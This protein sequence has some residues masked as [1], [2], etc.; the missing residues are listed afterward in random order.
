MK[1]AKGG[2]RRSLLGSLGVCTAVVVMAG[3]Y[4]HTYHVGA[5]APTGT[6][7]Y[8]QWRHHWLA[9]LIDPDQ[10]MALEEI[11]PSGNATIK[12]EAT[13]LNGLVTA[14]IG[15]VYSPTTVTVR[16]VTGSDADLEFDEAQIAKIVSDPSFLD[17]VEA[18]S[19]ELLEEA[20]D[21]QLLL[22]R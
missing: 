14:L 3:C 2:W 6:I 11:C 1:K 8:D 9:G 4:E 20:T 13:F 7:V 17:W 15:V 22:D 12:N 21:A 16:C 10:E 19:P 5:G 18:V